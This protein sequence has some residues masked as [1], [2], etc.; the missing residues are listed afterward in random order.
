MKET[1]F[2]LCEDVRTEADDKVSLMGVMT[3]EVTLQADPSAK[4][5]LR[6]RLAVFVGIDVEE[7]DV[8]ATFELGIKLGEKIVLSLKGNVSRDVPDGNRVHF[9]AGGDKLR[10]PGPGMLHFFFDVKDPA[11]NQLLHATKRLNIVL[12]KDDPVAQSA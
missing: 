9:M 2:I 12:E 11:G 3:R 7:G 6:M 4:A 8:P 1:E 5:P 10:L